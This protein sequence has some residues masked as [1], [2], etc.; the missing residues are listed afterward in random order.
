MTP[1]TP[2]AD[3]LVNRLRSCALDLEMW[4]KAYESATLTAMRDLNAEAADRIEAQAAEIARLKRP[5]DDEGM[6]EVMAQAIAK[7]TE[8]SVPEPYAPEHWED[9]RVDARFAFRAI[10][11]HIRAREAAAFRAGA[12]AMREAA[13]VAVRNKDAA[14]FYR[15]LAGL[16]Q[17]ESII[18]ALPLPDHQSSTETK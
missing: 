12:E 16:I 18:R 13:A 15:Q 2:T 7:V 9:C 14:E 4:A 5:M 17:A 10:A 11:P 8:T 6:V 1:P 3:D